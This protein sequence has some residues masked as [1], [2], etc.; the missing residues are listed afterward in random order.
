MRTYDPPSKLEVDMRIWIAD[1]AALFA[2]LVF[3]V[4]AFS[5]ANFAQAVLV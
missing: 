3:M 1:A 5:V 2:L 4:S